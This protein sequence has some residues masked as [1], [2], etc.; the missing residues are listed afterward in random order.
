MARVPH[1]RALLPEVIAE[2]D[3]REVGRRRERRAREHVEPPALAPHLLEERG[4]LRVVARVARDRDAL[5]ARRRN[6]L[7]R[8]LDG[9]L[10]E[11]GASVGLVGQGDAAAA[12]HRDSGCGALSGERKNAPLKS[13]FPTDP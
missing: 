12:T 6:Q 8:R 11:E 13:M 5:A 1:R 2:R 10:D 4:D 9:R 3:A 7:A